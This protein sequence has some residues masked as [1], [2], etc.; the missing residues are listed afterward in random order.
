LVSFETITPFGE[1]AI[2]YCSDFLKNIGFN[3][4]KLKFK[5]VC[6]LYAKFGQF[7]RNSC[8][9]GHVDV[10][11]PIGNWDTPPFLLAKT[12]LL[13]ISILQS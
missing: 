7:N 4:K 3:C 11:L 12:L 5:N 9:A 8:F 6:N 13:L 2:D 1:A 10:V